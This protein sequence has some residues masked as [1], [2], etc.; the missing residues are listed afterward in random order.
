MPPEIGVRSHCSRAL[1]RQRAAIQAGR[2]SEQARRQRIQSGSGYR[3]VMV[4]R[5]LRIGPLVGAEVEKSRNE[6]ALNMQRRTAVETRA[7]EL[8]LQA[9]AA[10]V[11]V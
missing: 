3:A 10:Q 6:H 8:R 11:T 9:V 5:D 2:I 1:D 7:S 4:E